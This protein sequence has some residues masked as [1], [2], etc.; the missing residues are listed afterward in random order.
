MSKKSKKTVEDVAKLQKTINIIEKP[1]NMSKIRGKTFHN[2]L[3]LST[4][5]PKCLEIVKISKICKKK[6]SGMSKNLKKKSKLS[7]NHHTCQK[8]VAKRPKIT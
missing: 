1:S 3:K 7:K 8:L 4:N 6:H 5:H 2:Y